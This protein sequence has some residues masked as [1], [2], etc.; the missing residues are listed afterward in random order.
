[1]TTKITRSEFAQIAAEYEQEHGREAAWLYVLQ[2]Y[3]SADEVPES[4]FEI[5]AWATTVGG[6]SEITAAVRAAANPKAND[7]D[8]IHARAWA[9]RRAPPPALARWGLQQAS[10]ME[11]LADEVWSRVKKPKAKVEEAESAE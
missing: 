6:P 3:G 10:T 7:E 9:G 11:E 4:L 8:S 1:M 2:G 5:G